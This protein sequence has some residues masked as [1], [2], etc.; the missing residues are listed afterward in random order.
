MNANPARAKEIFVAALKRPPEQW[1]AY[2]DEVAGNDAQLRQRVHDLLQAHAQADSFLESPAPHLDATVEESVGA[3]PGTVIGPYKLLEQIGEGG[4]GLVFVAEQ[5]QPVRRQVALKLIKPGMDTREV[6]R[7]FEAERQALAL[8]D[9]PNIARVLDAGATEQG[10]PY[11]VME[12]VY[13]IPITQ[14]CDDNRLTPRQRLELFLPICQAVQHAHTK[15]II[16]RDLKPSNL[17]VSRHEGTALVKVIDFGVAKAVGQPLTDTPVYTHFLQLIGTPLYMSPEQ[18]GLSG[19]DIDTR[20]DI[21]ALGVLLYEL[22]TGTTPFDQTRLRDVGFDEIR[23][24]IREEEPPRPSTRISTLGPAAATVSA[25]RQSDPKRLSRL[26]RGE[27]DWMVMKALEKDRGRRYETASAFAAD[28]QRYLHDEPVQ[29]CPP[30]AWYRFGKFARRNKA[31]LTVA[32]GLLV[33]LLAAGAGWWWLARLE[34]DQREE[35]A[36]QEAERREEVARLEGRDRQ[37]I[38]TALEQAEQFLLQARWPEAEAAL[39]QAERRL[40]AG[41]ADDLKQRLRQAR[42]NLRLVQRL[43]DIRLQ[44]ATLVDGKWNPRRAGPAYAAAFQEHGLDVLAGE[45][46][47]LA[48]RIGMS[49]VKQ[50]LVAALEDW[51]DL[52]DGKTLARLLA[53][54]R[55]ADPDALRN[56]FRDPAVWQDRQKLTEQACEANV[57]QLSPGL[58]QIIAYRLHRLGGPGL[59]LLERGQRR[60]PEDFWLN[61]QLAHALKTKKPTPWDVVVGCYQ[62]ALAVRPRAAAVWN[63]LGLALQAKGDLDG[64]IAAFK[65]AITLDAKGVAAHSNLGAALAVKGDLD[66]AIAQT[67][68]AIA[69]DPKD[70]GAHYNLG[71]VLHMKG[72]Q[73]G[74][75]A[76]Y[77]KALAF[78]PRYA[79]AHSNLGTELYA[80]RDVAGAIAEYRKAI[81]LDPKCAEAHYNLGLALMK[82]R[83]LDGAIAAFKKASALDPQDAEAHCN[84]GAGL[85]FKQDLDG[86]IAAFHK[87]LAL[88]PKYATAHSNLGVALVRKGDLDGAIAACKKAIVFVPKDAEAHYNLGVALARKGDL[89]GAIAACKKAIAIDSKFAR[90]HVDLGQA[91]LKEGHFAEARAATK[92]ALELLPAGQHLHQMAS[93]QLRQCDQLLKLDAKLAAV[94]QG[95]AKPHDAAEQL[96]LADF[97]DE[98]KKCYAAAARFYAEAFKAEPKLAEN[99]RQPHRYNAA[100]AAALAGCGQGNDA[101][102]LDTQERLRWCRQA[103]AW[104]R[105]DLALWTKV[106]NSDDPQ[107]RATARQ[108]LTHWQRD[109]DLAGLRDLSRLVQWPKAERESCLDL[110]ADVS[111]T[112]AR[113]TP[114]VKEVAPD[115]R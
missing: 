83:D 24:I 104:L 74:A 33:A 3:G 48:Q 84:L 107:A 39:S 1:D 27:L 20:S 99:L 26:C 13:G 98:F 35:V 78:N 61:F 69:V 67:N 81:A 87:A 92:R 41:G 40:A 103:L 101:T 85:L 57:E 8:M 50:H 5:L 76:A 2:L 90:A 77:Q 114:K 44:A 22:L 105:A 55:R 10:R 62:A 93:Q 34:A 46:A 6:I 75:I 108:E 56:Q 100:C 30:S 25:Q 110:W 14:F 96:A 51:A 109:P 9:H 95:K 17:L 58:L 59:E 7:R 18:A 38:Q 53:V 36:R 80:K 21:Y 70:P 64:A 66:G 4:M 29:A 31:R 43:D 54:A 89:D 65:R 60:Y 88:N 52:S 82:E 12:L 106:L 47:E 45:E 37:A 111:A 15:G 63:N 11:F 113:V 102:Q 68:Q 115:K 19:L 71:K 23:R 79:L 49:P 72:D 94:L 97:C 32:V 112:L 86:A 91:L 73:D 28:V 16:H 42:D